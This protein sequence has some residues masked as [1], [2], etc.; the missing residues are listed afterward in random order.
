MMDSAYIAAGA[1]TGFLVGLTGVGGGALMTPIL[2]LLFGFSPV[3]AIATDLWFASITKIVAVF[4]HQRENKIDWPI[5]R[6]LWCG[7]LPVATLVVFL[8]NQGVHIQKVHWLTYAIGL[9]IILTSLGLLFAPRLLRHLRQLGN[10]HQPEPIKPFMTIISGA[11]VGLCVAL[12]SIGAGTLGSVMMIYLYPNRMRPHQLVAS[13][14]MHAI[15][16]A[17]VAGL[18][19]LSN[20]LVNV[21][22]LMN[23]LT[24]SVPAVILGSLLAERCSA[25]WLQGFLACVLMMVGIK[26]LI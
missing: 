8:L 2:L 15:P 16:L 3:T 13:D 1:I 5:I 23:L 6:L 20:H 12:T 17:I 26:T 11:C 19:F 25:R 14:I 22:V 18:G 4:I 7:S 10:H 9:M 21:P 24:G